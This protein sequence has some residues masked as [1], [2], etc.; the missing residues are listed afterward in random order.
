MAEPRP[1]LTVIW[2]RDIPAQ[3]TAKAGRETARTQLDE[4][5][6]EAVDAAAMS[7][8]LAGSDAYLAQWRREARPCGDDLGAEVASEVARLDS[9]YTDERLAGSPAG[10]PGGWAGWSDGTVLSSPTRES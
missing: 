4:R 1:T 8:G 2:W 6:S 10:R 7:A 9:A 3:V 5:F